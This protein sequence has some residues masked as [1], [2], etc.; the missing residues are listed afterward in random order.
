MHRQP[1]SD[2]RYAFRATLPQPTGA[3]IG[4]KASG[5]Q[6]AAPSPLAAAS[7]PVTPACGAWLANAAEACQ[8]RF[9]PGVW[10]TWVCIYIS[11]GGWGGGGVLGCG[12][13][14]RSQRSQVFL[15]C[16]GMMEVTHFF[17]TCNSPST[18][19]RAPQRNANKM[20]TQINRTFVERAS[21]WWIKD[22]HFKWVCL[23]AT[24]EKLLDNFCNGSFLRKVP[25]II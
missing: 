17:F 20:Q 13:R 24:L 4:G 7:Q 19:P 16:T 5:Q 23:K 3:C 1:E 2:N 15:W 10:P 22:M 11:E 21:Q 14:E 12:G 25:S 8:E 18:S 9:I 6:Q